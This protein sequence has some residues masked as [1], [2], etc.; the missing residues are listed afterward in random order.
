MAQ[1][2]GVRIRRNELMVLAVNGE[3]V[4]TE[5]EATVTLIIEGKKLKTSVMILKSVVNGID[6]IIGMDVINRYG[7]VHL[8][9]GKIE[10]GFVSIHAE[11]QAVGIKD[12]DFDAYFDGTKWTAKYKWKQ[13]QPQLRNS[14]AQ[15]K[16][17]PQLLHQFND[18]MDVWVKNGWLKPCNKEEKSTIGIVPLMAVEQENKGKIRPV[19]DFR[20]LNQYVNSHNASSD[21]CDEKVRKWRTVGDKFATLD[22][23][24]AYMQIHID[25]SLWEHQKVVYKE[26]KYYL[27]FGLNSAPKIMS[28]VLGSV[29]NLNAGISEATDHYIDDIIVNLEKTSVEK[30]VN[31]LACYGLVTK[32]PVQCDTTRVLGLQLFRN[33]KKEL[34]WKRGNIIPKSQNIKTE[35]VTRRKLF[36][37]C[38]HLLGHYPVGGWLRIACSFI[39]RH[40]QGNTWDDLIGDQAQSWLIEILCRL[41]V[42][43]SVRGKWNA[44]GIQNGATLWCDASSMAIGVAIEYD[45]VIIEDAAWLR[46]IN[47]VMHINIAELDAVVRGINLAA[48]W[49]IKNLSVFTDSVTVHGWLKSMLTESHRIRSNALSEMLIKRRLSLLQDLIKEY[50]INITLKWVPSSKNKADVLTRVPKTWLNELSRRSAKELCGVSIAEEIRNCHS[51]RRLPHVLRKD[52]EE[53]VRKCC[54]CNSIDPAPIK[55]ENGVLDVPDTWY[56]VACDVTHY[57]GSPYL[58]MIDCG[59]SRFAI[60]RKLPREDTKNVMCNRPSGNGI[61][62]RNHR[63]VKRTAAR[64]QICPLLAVFW[65]NATPTVGTNEESA[66]ASQKKKYVWRLPIQEE[67]NTETQESSRQVMKTYRIGE[68]VYVRPADAKCT[69]VW[70]IGTVTDILTNTNIEIDGVPRHVRDVRIAPASNSSNASSKIVISEEVD[71]D[72]SDLEDLDIFA[73]REE[74]TEETVV[75][76][77]EEADGREIVDNLLPAI[78]RSTRERKKPTY[79]NDYVT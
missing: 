15:Y 6:A 78:R 14:V 34:C 12:K 46:S 45:G 33:E 72:E 57:K 39:K 65:Y 71:S 37:I 61:V 18:E 54:Q 22:L 27:G 69:S 20:E 62:E 29:L 68:K 58:T 10:F 19:L 70:K 1:K 74:G 21:A 38:G 41:E 66:P 44:K 47:D 79:L 53:C 40:S 13:G 63:T 17:K 64:A 50:N 2:A 23:R 5:G 73:T 35:K 11:K 48:K 77:E 3:F 4:K 36:S 43:D 7:G 8:Y 25:P 52:V 26:E 59:P 56:R 76:A 67:K 32:E 9:N 30:V 60:W 75:D 31:H 24:C 51:K 16:V 28:S 55:W 49:D 42:C